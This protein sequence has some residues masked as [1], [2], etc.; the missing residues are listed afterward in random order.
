MTYFRTLSTVGFVSTA[1]SY[2]PGRMGFGLFVPDLKAALNL[3]ASIVGF[4]SSFGFFGYFLALLVAQAMLIRLGPKA[5]VVTGL[6]SAAFGMATVAAATNIPLLAIGV[7]FASASAGFAWTPFNDAVNRKVQ[8]AVR[9]TALSLISTGTSV[10]IILAAI[11]AFAAQFAGLSWRASWTFFAVGAA[12][13]ALANWIGLRTVEPSA[14]KVS[15]DDR[16]ALFHRLALPL[17][18]VA[19]TL[20]T[21]SAIYIAFAA[22]HI[23]QSARLPGLPADGSPAALFF[24]YGVFGLAGLITG[25]IRERIGLACLLRALMA[26]CAMSLT[27]LTLWPNIWIALILSAGAQGMAVMMTSAVLAFWSD[28]L[29]PTLPS[30]AFTV[31]LLAYAAGSILGP[32]I[33]GIASDAFGANAMF[34]G[35]AFL[36]ALMALALNN[37]L[38]RDAEILPAQLI[39]Y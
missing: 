20:G 8:N 18:A 31:A 37:R 30:L 34:L 12:I 6:S 11:A 26:T 39:K 10:G 5:P 13:A 35:A 29:F 9:P 17:Y 36:P 1:I 32:A 21:V 19:F 14:S 3:S 24:I 4:V 38:V 28:R 25:H 16:H 23:R 27:L 15:A 33:A 7:F 22:D 2:G